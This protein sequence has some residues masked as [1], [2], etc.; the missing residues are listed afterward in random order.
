MNKWIALTT[1]FLVEN[2]TG[3][4]ATKAEKR[5]IFVLVSC[6]FRL[7]EALLEMALVGVMNV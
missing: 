4:R 5:H 2:K 7:L 3:R 6:A 1:P